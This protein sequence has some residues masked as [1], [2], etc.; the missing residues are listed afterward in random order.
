M[1]KGNGADAARR[2]SGRGL[3]RT[4][5]LGLKKKTR[6]NAALEKKREA[7]VLRI[8]HGKGVHNPG[9]SLPK[10][11]GKKRLNL[12]Q[13][14]KKKGRRSNGQK[15]ESHFLSHQCRAASGAS[16]GR[17]RWNMLIFCGSR[18]L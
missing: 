2:R 14:R 17:K 12:S 5:A 15:K 9:T 1:G 16:G 10:E 4:F 8:M 18:A 11:A 3:L 6:S 7:T 13:G